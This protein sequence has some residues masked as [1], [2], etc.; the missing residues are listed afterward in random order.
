M[1]RISVRL[2]GGCEVLYGGA[3]LSFPSRK[4]A[5]LFA[6][7]IHNRRTGHSRG[8]LADLLWPDT[9][10]MS[11]RRNLSTTLWRVKLAVR[12][13]RGLELRVNGDMVS[14]ACSNDV[15]DLDV[16]TFTSLIDKKQATD[17]QQLEALVKAEALYRGDFL[18]GFD[19]Q[20]CED[21]RRHYATLHHDLLSK[22]AGAFIERGD[23]AR[24]IAYLQKLIVVD[25]LSEEAVLR[26]MLAYHLTGKRATAL[27]LFDQFRL[28]LKEELGLDPPLAAMGLYERIRHQGDWTI[29]RSLAAL[30]PGL[31]RL[32]TQLVGRE[33]ELGMLISFL[34][35]TTPRLTI[36]VIIGEGGV[37]KS[38]LVSAL[39]EEAILRGY[40][41]LY[42]RCPN[43]ET[44]PPYQVF[45]Q[46]L[47]PRVERHLEAG[48]PLARL[49]ERLAGGAAPQIGS[50]PH[51]FAPAASSPLVAEVLLRLLTERPSGR[52][53]LIV[54][55]DLHHI[56][57][58]SEAVLA[59][60]VGRVSSARLVVVATARESVRP[61]ERLLRLLGSQAVVLPLQPLQRSD[62][63]K[64]AAT[65]LNVRTIPHALSEILWTTTAGVPLFILELIKYLIDKGDLVERP[66]GE[67]SLNSAALTSIRPS[68]P[69]R[70]ME[71]LRRRV[72]GLGRP[73]RELLLC[74]AAFGS[75]ISY[76]ELVAMLG[77][78]LDRLSESTELLLHRG[79]VVESRDGLRFS[80]EIVRE[81]ALSTIT[82]ARRRRLHL[83]A[84]EILE[85]S[86]AQAEVLVWH[87]QEAGDFDRACYYSEVSGDAARV[88]HANAD[89]LRWYTIALSKHSGQQAN[90]AEEAVRRA[91]LL[92][93]RQ[94]VLD[95]IGDREGQ[96]RDIR[97][98]LKLAVR[99]GDL[100]LRAEAEYYHS[101]LLCR[102][103]LNAKALS[104]ASSAIRMYQQVGDPLGEANASES[105]GLAH[106]NVRD[107][108]SAR[109]AFRQALKLFRKARDIGGEARALMHLGTLMALDGQGL[110]ALQHLD[111]AERILRLLGDKRSLAGA[112]LQK[113]ILRRDRGQLRTS[114]A[115][116]KSGIAMMREVGDRIGEA[117]GLSQL[118]HTHVA[119]GRIR[120]GMHEA[121]RA[122][123]MAAQARDTR[124][125]IVFLNN[126][127]YGSLRA[128]GDFLRAEQ[129]IGRAI[130][131]VGESGC[132]ENLANYYDSMA[133]VLLDKGEFA[134]ALRWARE[135]RAAYR[136]WRGR[137]KFLGP[138]IDLRLGRCYLE[139]RDYRR[140]VTFLKSAAEAWKK[141]DERS[142]RIHA[143]ALIAVAYAYESRFDQAII[144]ARETEKLLQSVDG[145]E[146]LHLVQ[147]NQFVTFQRLGSFAAAKRA[148]RRAYVS[149]LQQSSGLKGRYKRRFL[150]G[151][152]LNREILNEVTRT[153]GL[154]EDSSG[155][156][157]VVV[158]VHPLAVLGVFDNVQ[159]RRR[160]VYE[161]ISAGVLTQREI[162]LRLGVSER[163]V[164]SDVAKLKSGEDELVRLAR[165][166]GSKA[167]P[168]ISDVVEASRE[169]GTLDYPQQT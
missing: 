153:F 6:Y 106:M 165:G 9:D 32:E 53:T 120:E 151:I 125:T 90:S 78:P 102:E 37:G 166:G 81:A 158:P 61:T 56:D 34:T 27:A 66:H 76:A 163:T 118:S 132:Q 86:G 162:A 85:R 8:R 62:T 30:P 160:A 105:L 57:Q 155:I 169:W 39:R 40:D 7:L 119:M 15:L 58:A 110:G 140:A 26:L 149:L 47:W 69:K 92:L 139:L 124:A 74:A 10:E 108:S 23:Y 135:S 164:R 43:L 46:A 89:A 64:L 5:M 114:E 63:E 152:P 22:I 84:A 109:A 1:H 21:D 33:S 38:R 96:A 82:G 77:R 4:A 167:A 42:G 147:W 111:R 36:C 68:L 55:E 17:E 150:D 128:L 103:N 134:E 91:Q 18:E 112:V 161:Y 59:G 80:H 93:K 122:V 88:L 44:S 143:V 148:L 97:E 71:V 13:V 157:N 75:E 137:S 54:L 159:E 12:S 130:G 123:H 131:L 60:L 29:P 168:A 51:E 129:F 48:D 73:A 98:A 79:F 25:P 138:Q 142:L 16:E 31:Q 28:R 52:G 127:A 117:R 41:V 113:G 19:C 11:A 72:E 144:Y 154:R 20:W 104:A 99:V 126:A 107:Q 136:S 70:L 146:Q 67:I 49:L 45:I 95:L 141:E 24:S 121:R 156:S 83:R 100:R 133:A 50:S 65:A 145:V 87:F 14:L 115:L 3:P 94:A 116:L 101:R 2:L 35:E